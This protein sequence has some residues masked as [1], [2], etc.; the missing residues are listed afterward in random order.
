MQISEIPAGK[1]SILMD[2]IERLS[3]KSLAKVQLSNSTLVHSSYNDIIDGLYY[4]DSPFMFG[5][6]PSIV[7][8]TG[9]AWE[10][11]EQVSILRC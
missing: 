4:V 9:A 11:Q 8:N 10:T 6:D 5:N 1:L 7:V 2:N 3:E